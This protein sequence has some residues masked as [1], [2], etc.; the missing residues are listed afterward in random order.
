MLF[1]RSA[2]AQKIQALGGRFP[3]AFLCLGLFVLLLVAGLLALDRLYPVDLAPRTRTCVVL[4]EDGTPLRAFADPNG[5]WRYPVTPE[6][7]SPL[8]VEALLGYE[9]RWFYRHPGINPVSMVR[10][11]WQWAASGRMP[12]VSASSSAFP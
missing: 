6:Q 11:A 4:A 3:R 1:N 12:N 7:V 9:D 5:V 2:V 8:Y 10:A